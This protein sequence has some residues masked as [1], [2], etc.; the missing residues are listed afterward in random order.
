MS[1][2]NAYSNNYIKKDEDDTSTWSNVFFL[3][4]VLVGYA[5]AIRWAWCGGKTGT[6]W[7]FVAG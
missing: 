7:V 6:V 2:A 4:Y 5:M 1:N 3:L